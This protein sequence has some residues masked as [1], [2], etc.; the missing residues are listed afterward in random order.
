[1]AVAW[2]N[3]VDSVFVATKMEFVLALVASTL[4]RSSREAWH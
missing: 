4:R 2:K 3:L 1:M